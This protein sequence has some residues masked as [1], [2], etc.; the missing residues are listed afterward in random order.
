MK[1]ARMYVNSADLEQ[2]IC[3]LQEITSAL[4]QSDAFTLST[5]GILHQDRSKT[6]GEN[7]VEWIN[8][9]YDVTAGIL[10]TAANA[11]SIVT[12]GFANDELSLE[13]KE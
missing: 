4:S 3:G 9:N 13:M 8:E 1:E 11:L 10:R 2:L 5:E 6:N 7:A 12:V